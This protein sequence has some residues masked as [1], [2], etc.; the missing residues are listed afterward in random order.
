MT[1][2][3][4]MSLRPSSEEV[5]D[6]LD[7]I[8]VEN[9]LNDSAE[10]RHI[11]VSDSMAAGKLDVAAFEF[12]TDSDGEAYVYDINTNTNYN[13]DAEQRANLSAMT[14]LASY[15]GDCL[16]KLTSQKAA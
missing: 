2:N 10:L 7:A 14:V 8:C 3:K 6:W 13:S 5:V 4:D 15:L 1:L 16:A 11:D 12:I 9:G